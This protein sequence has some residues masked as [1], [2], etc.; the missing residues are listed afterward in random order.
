MRSVFEYVYFFKTENHKGIVRADSEA[1]AA[2]RVE[3]CFSEPAMVW[4]VL[5]DEIIDYG[6]VPM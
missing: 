2:E 1:E 5:E 6:V 4:S 3:D